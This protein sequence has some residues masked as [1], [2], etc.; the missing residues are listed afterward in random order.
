M[1]CLRRLDLQQVVV[2]DN[3]LTLL[4]QLHPAIEEVDISFSPG[5]SSEVVWAFLCQARKLK[6]FEADRATLKIPQ[7][8]LDHVA[9]HSFATTANGSEG[10]KADMELPWWACRDLETLMIEFDIAMGSALGSRAMFAMLSRLPKLRYLR[11]A[12]TNIVLSAAGGIRQLAT[13]RRLKYFVLDTAVYDDLRRE[14]VDWMLEHW[15]VLKWLH[16]SR[17]SIHQLAA[18]KGWAE[19]CGRYDVVRL[20]S[21]IP[22]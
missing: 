16:L 7:V 13:L 4:V 8:L 10:Q 17:R 19:E 22:D 6:R 3:H 1:H 20:F 2:T 15:P 14:D 11:L 18:I 12:N 5:L 21:T 9:K